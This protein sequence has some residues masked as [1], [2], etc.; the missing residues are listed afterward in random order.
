[1]FVHNARLPHVL[2]PNLYSCPQ[3]Y[4]LEQDRLFAP[5]WHLVG[6]ISEAQNNGD[7]F[8]RDLAGTPIIVRNCDGE[9]HT[10]LNVCTHRHC[11]L[12]HEKSG[13]QPV[14]TCQYH[15]WE[16]LTDGRT[17]KIPEAQHFRPMPGGPECLKKFPTEVRGNLIF[18]SLRQTPDSLD[19]QLGPLLEVCNEFPASRWKQ[20]DRWSYE[21]N[22]NWKIVV[23]NTVESY[24]VSTVHPKTLVNFGQE[25]NM[26][27]VIADNST[28]MRSEIYAPAAYLRLSNWLLPTLEPGC[29]HLYN[30][31]HGFPNIFLIRIDAMLQVMIVEPLSPETCRLTVYVFILKAAQESLRSRLLTS[32]WGRLKSGVVKAVLAED[33]RLYPDLQRGMKHSPF[34]G[35]ISTR[36]E[37]VY[38]FQD[39]VYRQC[40]LKDT[41]EQP[42]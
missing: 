25:E 40:N 21:F 9:W 17:G 39:Y 36:E 12:T 10:F 6:T 3:Q 22:A 30:L 32:V 7:F 26:Q 16:F 4:A 5:V 31:Y 14:L 41:I 13:H 15:G 2:R 29:R 19:S 33:A 1:M 28:I 24:H 11:M 35:T 18:V 42:A 23:E 20:C 38:A 27:H 8:T 37:L 34:Q